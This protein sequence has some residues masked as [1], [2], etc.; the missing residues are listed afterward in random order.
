M[1]V[2][3]TA[4]RMCADATAI[5]R[6]SRPHIVISSTPH[7]RAV[8]LCAATSAGTHVTSEKAH[9]M[10]QVPGVSC[11]LYALVYAQVALAACTHICLCNLDHNDLAVSHMLINTHC[12][13]LRLHRATLYALV[14]V[15]RRCMKVS[16]PMTISNHDNGTPMFK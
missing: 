2:C 3:H 6:L 11:D 14:A 5:G 8:S 9:C 13:R 10:W 15:S 16:L 1:R 12:C 7:T 4:R